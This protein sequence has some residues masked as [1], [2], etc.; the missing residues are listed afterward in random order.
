MPNMSYK[1]TLTDGSDFIGLTDQDGYT[2]KISSNSAQI[3]KIEVPYYDSSIDTD[4]QSD[5]C[6]C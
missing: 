4:N 6:Y 3:A 1:I 5:T 2:E